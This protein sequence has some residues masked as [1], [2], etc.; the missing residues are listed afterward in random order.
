[1][2]GPVIARRPRGH[3][4]HGRPVLSWR[5]VP[6]L[7]VT[8]L[9]VTATLGF[10]TACAAGDDIARALRGV[11]HDSE[12]LATSRWRPRDVTLPP[13]AQWPSE[14][15]IASEAVRLAA[16]VND[17]PAQE[18]KAAVGEACEVADAVEA[19]GGT[20]ADVADYLTTRT[21]TSLSYRI[22]IQQLAEDLVAAD[23]TTDQTLV[24]AR[25]TVCTWAG[26]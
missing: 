25:I 13:P 15:A 6:G 5:V 8:G 19:L 9:V 14:D 10:A 18:R 26:T 1:M 23:S 17:V 2:S 12:G 24:L 21:D 16:P 7:V 11:A 22:Q 3:A 20:S 4:S